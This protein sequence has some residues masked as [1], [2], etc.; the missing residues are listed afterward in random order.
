MW[1]NISGGDCS[2]AMAL[3]NPDVPCVFVVTGARAQG[4]RYQGNIN[5]QV[6]M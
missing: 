6:I 3:L 1:N 5:Q 4:V 2:V